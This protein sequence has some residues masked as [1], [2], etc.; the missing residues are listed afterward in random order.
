[1]LSKPNSKPLKLYLG[2]FITIYYYIYIVVYRNPAPYLCVNTMHRESNEDARRCNGSSIHFGTGQL[3]PIIATKGA[4]RGHAPRLMAARE[5]ASTPAS[6]ATRSRSQ[7][8]QQQQQQQPVG[9]SSSG[10]AQAS[11][12]A[13]QGGVTPPIF[14]ADKG[15]LQ[16]LTELELGDLAKFYEVRSFCLA[17][18]RDACLAA[19][20]INVSVVLLLA[21]ATASWTTSNKRVQW[22]AKI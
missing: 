6:R 5:Q 7:Q 8:Q 19:N 4:K 20:L 18:Q 3:V 12:S 15:Q 1:M 9:A 22:P 11:S 2:F 10:A 16:E 14:P 17:L 13:G 21:T